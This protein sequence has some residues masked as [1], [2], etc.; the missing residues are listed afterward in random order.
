MWAVIFIRGQ[1]SCGGGGGSLPWLVLVFCCH[2][3]VSDV[4][5]GFPVSK[6]SGG[7]GVFTHLLAVVVASDV[8]TR[9]VSLVRGWCW[10]LVA[11]GAIHG[12]H[13]VVVVLSSRRMVLSCCCCGMVVICCGCG[14]GESSLSSVMA[15]DV[16][17]L[18]HSDGV[19]ACPGGC[20]WWVVVW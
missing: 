14:C 16:V 15:A 7:K 5:P 10:A 9:H 8:G 17:F 13:V 2:V 12:W 3:T 1:L 4:A 20:R 18:H 19:P 6:E 11:I